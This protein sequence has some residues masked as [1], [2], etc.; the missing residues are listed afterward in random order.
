[1]S[2]ILNFLDHPFQTWQSSVLFAI[3]FT[4]LILVCAFIAKRYLE[5]LRINNQQSSHNPLT[6]ESLRPLPPPAETQ[7]SAANVTGSQLRPRQPIQFN[8]PVVAMG[9]VYNSKIAQRRRASF[10]LGAH[11]TGGNPTDI[12]CHT[13]IA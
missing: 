9:E 13:S 3:V 8:V 7:Y 1:M 6:L 11:N 2:P 12:P 10:A 4:C 5:A